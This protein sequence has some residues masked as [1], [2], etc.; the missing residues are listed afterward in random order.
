MKFW[1][2]REI[3]HEFIFYGGKLFESI[4]NVVYEH[5]NKFDFCFRR[6]K[7]LNPIRIFT[8]FIVQTLYKHSIPNIFAMSVHT[9]H[10]LKILR[11]LSRIDWYYSTLGTV[12]YFMYMYISLHISLIALSSYSCFYT[13]ACKNIYFSE[14]W[15]STCYRLVHKTI[16]IQHWPQN[17]IYSSVTL[18][19]TTKSRDYL[20][21]RGG[22]PAL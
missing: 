4:R 10:T 21:D 16:C 6:K 18:T 2:C 22:Q 8:I 14:K 1:E 3:R 7:L 19:V 17:Y 5:T 12:N 11:F 13:S 9:E 15:Y 20:N